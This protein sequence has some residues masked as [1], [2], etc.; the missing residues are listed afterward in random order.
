[1]ALGTHNTNDLSFGISI[2]RVQCKLIISL[3]LLKTFSC[4]CFEQSFFW[5]PGAMGLLLA[6]HTIQYQQV[7]R[8][9]TACLKNHTIILSIV[10]LSPAGERAN[11]PRYAS[12]M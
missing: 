2:K 6:N 1:M 7:R 11:P 8:T 12:T 9:I 3:I 10:F 4:N 5:W